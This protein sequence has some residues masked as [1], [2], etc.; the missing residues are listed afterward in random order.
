MKLCVA[1]MELGV[2]LRNTKNA[3][4]S[5]NDGKKKAGGRLTWMFQSILRGLYASQLINWANYF[6]ATQFLIIKSEEFYSDARTVMGR[7]EKFLDID[8]HDWTELGRDGKEI[9]NFGEGNKVKARETGSDYAPMDNEIR[10]KLRRIFTRYNQDLKGL[11]KDRQF[12]L[13]DYSD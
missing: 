5:S 8:A 2:P 10:K 13:W 6:P 4:S 11:F 9:Y 3:D 1:A 7:V 12:P